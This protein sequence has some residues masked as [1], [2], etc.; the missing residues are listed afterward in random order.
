[1][2]TFW[3]CVA[4]AAIGTGLTLGTI[5]VVIPRFFKALDFDESERRTR[6]R[7]R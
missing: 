1:M 6:R 7:S 4:G 2:N 5:Y 3:K